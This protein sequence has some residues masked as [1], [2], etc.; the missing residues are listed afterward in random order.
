MNGR[1]QADCS[2]MAAIHPIG[3]SSA[4]VREVNCSSRTRP[5]NMTRLV[6]VPF[7]CGQEACHHSLF[8]QPL[9]ANVCLIDFAVG[10]RCDQLR[11]IGRKRD[12]I[13]RFAAEFLLVQQNQLAVR[14]VPQTKTP[15][16]THGG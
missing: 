7:F 6:A 9:L 5:V 13:E 10:S 3:L 8:G 2:R 12:G 14:S 16:I 1:S 15:V 11:T 4:V